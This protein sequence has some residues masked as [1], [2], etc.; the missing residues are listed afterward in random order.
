MKANKPKPPSLFRSSNTWFSYIHSFIVI[1]LCWITN[2]NVL[3]QWN[4]GQT[5][6]V[7]AFPPEF[8]KK[9]ATLLLPGRKADLP[10]SWAQNFFF[11]KHKRE[12][13]H[14]NEKSRKKR[15]VVFDSEYKIKANR[16]RLGTTS[17]VLT[18]EGNVIMLLGRALG[19]S[20]LR[21]PLTSCWRTASL[22]SWG[23]QKE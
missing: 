11:P 9:Y 10:T 15:T 20:I 8:N 16:I 3:F 5:Q 6:H 23:L 13:A 22:T 17:S 4:L 2:V 19:T 1:L 7:S 12:G 14:R 21:L 18:R